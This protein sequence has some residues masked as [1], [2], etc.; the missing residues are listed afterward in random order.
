MKPKII[1]RLIEAGKLAETNVPSAIEAIKASS[2]TWDSL[3][4]GPAEGWR[5]AG[6][7]LFHDHLKCLARALA[8]VDALPM[9]RSGS[10]APVIWIFQELERREDP[11][12]LSMAE[13]I[14]EHD[15]ENGYVPFGTMAH[16]EERL[17]A[18]RAHDAHK[19]LVAERR[20][21]HAVLEVKN[22][23]YSNDL[24]QQLG[25][26]EH[27]V[28]LNKW[29]KS[30]H[31]EMSRRTQEAE[32]LGR[33]KAE[34]A[35]LAR[36]CAGRDDEVAR[37]TEELLTRDRMIAKL[38]RDRKRQS[39]IESGAILNSE[40]RFKFIFRNP[41][42]P[43]LSL[44]EEWACHDEKVLVFLKPE[45]RNALISRMQRIRRGP[46]RGVYNALCKLEAGE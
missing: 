1:G 2:L 37:L 13:W 23:E 35:E 17:N 29:L 39:I 14:V 12:L 21:L 16:R 36:K 27:E 25:S 7:T 31:D 6:Q 33:A 11:E 9:F 46:W 3:H 38:T 22:S 8:L 42:L 28:S 32:E 44:P 30:Q 4:K 26:L 15:Q 40:D 5:A 20:E 24:R 43:I 18:L 45:I 34:V 19:K 10:V 41:Q